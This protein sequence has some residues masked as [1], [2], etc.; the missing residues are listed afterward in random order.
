MRPRPALPAVPALL[1][2]ALALAL[3]APRAA[4]QANLLLPADSVE[5]L[6]GVIPFELRQ[7]SDT[8]FEGDRTQRVVLAYAD[9]TTLGAKWAKSAPRGEEFNNEPRYEIAA[10]AI[11]KLFLDEPDYVVPPTVAR[12]VPLEMYRVYEPDVS[13]TFSGTSSV[14]VVLQYWLFNVAAL[15]H[16]DKDRL[17]SDSSYARHFGN[18]NVLTYLIR[19][20][21]AN[22]GNV[23]ISRE[24][25][26]PRMFSVDNGVAFASAESD[27]GNDWKFLRTDRLPR[28]TVERLRALRR[29]DLE[30]ALAVVAQFEIRDGQLVPVPPPA[31][32]DRSDGVRRRGNLLQL[33]LTRR[34]IDAVD[35][36]RRS[37]LRQVDAGKVRVF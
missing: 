2:L 10:Y 26:Q 36:R 6:L 28:A 13:P 3:P 14:L 17:E 21:D 4:S 35:S 37:L 11:Q 7:R 5:R 19:Q 22:S 16:V 12:G 8:R 31:N 27:R 29:E 20:S 30:R 1:A 23:L 15:D 34:E 9:G 33:G 18:L 32:L 24:S 25:L